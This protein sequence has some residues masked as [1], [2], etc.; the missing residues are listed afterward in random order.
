MT[1]KFLENK[2]ST[3]KIVLSWRFPRKKKKRNSVF[4]RFASPPPRHPPQKGKFYFYCRLAVSESTEG[5]GHRKVCPLTIVGD[6]YRIPEK[7]PKSSADELYAS[8]K[9]RPVKRLE[10]YI[11]QKVSSDFRMVAKS[12]VTVIGPLE[13]T[14]A[15]APTFRCCFFLTPS[16]MRNRRS[17]F[18]AISLVFLQILVDFQSISIDFLS[19]SISFSQLQSI[20]IS[21]LISF[22]QLTRSKTQEVIVVTDTSLDSPEKGNVDQMSEKCRETVRKMSEK[23]S[24]GAVNTI[25]GHFL[26]IFC[27]FGR[28]SCLVTLSNARPLQIY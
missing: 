1:T 3:F 21:V 5:W 26:D 15:T 27:L 17:Q 10:L 14:T 13:A 18:S 28:C 4:G 22:N 2:I 23:L 7:S 16:S 19:C 11:F 8:Q 9:I 6:F 12:S 20:L 24:G 25:F